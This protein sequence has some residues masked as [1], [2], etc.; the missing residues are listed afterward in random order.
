MN[1]NVSIELLICLCATSI[2]ENKYVDDEMLLTV[3]QA[4]EI[5]FNDKKISETIH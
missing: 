3:Y 5:Y 4:L 2:I 1:G